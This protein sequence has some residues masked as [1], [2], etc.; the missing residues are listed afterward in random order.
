MQQST[1]WAANRFSASQKI[2]TF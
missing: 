2:S 1:S